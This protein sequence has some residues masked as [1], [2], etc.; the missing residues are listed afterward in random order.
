ML[1]ALATLILVIVGAVLII[2][3]LGYGIYITF[4]PLTKTVKGGIEAMKEQDMQKAEETTTAEERE[5]GQSQVPPVKQ[6]PPS[7]KGRKGKAK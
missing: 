1:E 4:Y 6:H 7:R 5:E 3:V 2:C